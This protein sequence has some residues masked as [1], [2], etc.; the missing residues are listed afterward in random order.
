MFFN[1]KELKSRPEQV[2][3]NINRKYVKFIYSFEK[4]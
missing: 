3:I 1:I 4:N 2:V